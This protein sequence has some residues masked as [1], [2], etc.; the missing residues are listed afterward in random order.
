MVT[1]KLLSW[2]KNIC[3]AGLLLTTGRI[4]PFISSIDVFK[5]D[6]KHVY[7]LGDKHET[8]PLSKIHKELFFE[9]LQRMDKNNTHVIIEDTL[10]QYKDNPE[11]YKILSSSPEIIA[12]FL[13]GLTE[14]VRTLGY[15]AENIECRELPQQYQRDM[16]FSKGFEEYIIP[17][18]ERYMHFS[19]N[20][21]HLHKHYTAK[22]DAAASRITITREWLTHAYEQKILDELLF[23]ELAALPKAY[24]LDA[25]LFKQVC[26][27][28][29][30]YTNTI[31]CVG[32]AHA[33]EL[34]LFLEDRGFKRTN[35]PQLD[36][37][38]S[39]LKE[40]KDSFTRLSFM[41]NIKEYLEEYETADPLN[42]ASELPQVQGRIS[43]QLSMLPLPVFFAP[44]TVIESFIATMSPE[45]TGQKAAAQ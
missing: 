21:N 35:M 32:G 19:T 25:I 24:L 36:V 41:N 20:D 15:S 14:K 2:F 17:L 22:M 3:I 30:K 43:A 34:R 5:K 1:K 18:V 31:V 16:E 13:L 8:C 29:E 39:A 9:F 12:E 42:E 44:R 33:Y 26:A 28:L 23:S 4:A 10:E 7:I 38:E 45:K 37:V 11:I 6:E 40:F 27:A